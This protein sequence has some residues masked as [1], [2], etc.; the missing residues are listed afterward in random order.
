MTP[1]QR[2]RVKHGPLSTWQWAVVGAYLVAIV[3]S[4]YVGRTAS[5]AVDSTERIDQLLCV[6][7]QYLERQATTATNPESQKNIRLFA[8]SLRPLVPSCPPPAE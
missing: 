2:R 7:I 1:D 6:Q 3:L 8:V 4:F 5:A